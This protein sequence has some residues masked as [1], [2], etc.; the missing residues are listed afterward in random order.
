MIIQCN[1]S[2]I[3]NN[4][5][6]HVNDNILLMNKSN[7]QIP[8]GFANQSASL[9]VTFASAQQSV[10]QLQSILPTTDGSLEQS[11]IKY[12]ISCSHMALVLP[13]RSLSSIRI[14]S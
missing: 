4:P 12:S 6:N 5:I 14:V 9:H 13:V 2:D 10:Q 7:L 8:S 1:I 11:E 3:R